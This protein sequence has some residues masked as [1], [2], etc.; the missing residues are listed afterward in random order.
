V[1]G[2]LRRQ[3]IPLCVL[4]SILTGTLPIPTLAQDA[5]PSTS[6]ETANP[7][8]RNAFPVE[9]GAKRTYELQPGEDPENRLV[10]PFVKHVVTDQKNFWTAP[11]RLKAVD[12]R[13]IMPV[14]AVTGTTVAADSWI[15]KQV[16][17][18]PSQLQR[19]KQISDYAT[20]SLIG[21]SGGAFLL[22]HLTHNEH[23][24]ETAFLAGEAAINS[25]FAA[26]AFKEMTRR[27]R[28]YQSINGTFFQGGASF[29]S[30]H[31]AVAWSIAGVVAHEYPGPLTKLAA[32]GIASTISL[33]RVTSKQHFASDVIIGSLLGWYFGRQV[34]RAHHDPELG[35]TGWRS[36]AEKSEDT[37][38]ARNPNSMGSPTVPPD[39]WVYPLFERLAGLGYVQSAYMGL[40]P[41]TRQECARLLDEAGERLR[42][43]GIN[44]AEA[45]NIYSSLLDEFNEEVEH[46]NGTA[47]L[48]V[49]L[50]S[51]YTRTTGISGTPLNDG[52]H[53][54]QTIINDYGRPYARGFNSITGISGRAVAGPLSFSIRAEYQH[55]PSTPSY[56]ANVL[57]AIA[58]ADQTQPLS[59]AAGSVNRLALLDASVA[60][61]LKNVQFSFGRQSH[62]LGPDESG[63]FLT[64]DNAQPITQFDIQSVSPFRVPLVSK[65]LGPARI[66]FYLGQLSGQNWVFNPPNLL[67][68][69]FAPQPFIHGDKITFKPTTNLEMGFGITAI[70]GGPGLP[71]T[72]KEF[73]RTYYSHKS[74]I[75]ENPAKRFASVDFSYRV[76]GLRNWLLVYANTMVGDEISP[77][78]SGRALVNPGIFLPR[79][80]GIRKVDFRLEIAREPLTREFPPGFVYY[81]RR[82][83]SGLTNDGILIG[84]WVGRAGTGGRAWATYWLSPRTNFQL[85][86]RE[87]HVSQ[88]FL[89]GGRLRDVSARGQV[90][91]NSQSALEASVQ[92]ERWQ[93]PLL[94]PGPQSNLSASVQLTFTPHL[95]LHKREGQP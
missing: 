48:G 42:Y 61:T 16:P 60:V 58:Q 5:A 76:P 77:I 13:W 11:L 74:S 4:L 66:E 59:N 37:P 18:R 24:R 72:F 8:S 50:D 39:S 89:E 55:A 41:W 34:Y 56:S 31:S 10:S 3:H 44:D 17:D 47:N 70:F 20:Y 22:G 69:G 33:T 36:F 95:R 2:I 46:R 80:P 15:S 62:W 32:Y 49:T 94:A 1:T 40:R 27:P 84:S 23:M 75:E 45:Q 90:L 78:G 57:Q 19:S 65:L 43:G 7:F 79:I 53:F 86:Y 52:F 91:I 64:S 63:P 38:Q 88:R 85:A 26:Y 30:E 25:T 51:I 83:R 9:Q 35:G 12:L 82:Y 6:S 73:F 29:P 28:P 67:G 71:F 81:D 54:G 92:Y 21:A 87:Q 93:F 14:L 68:P